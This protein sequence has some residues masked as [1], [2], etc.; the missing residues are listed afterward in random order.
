MAIAVTVY[1][2]EDGQLH[3][4]REDAEFADFS[5]TMRE[6]IGDFLR[7]QRQ[8]DPD[9]HTLRLL[10]DWELWKFGGFAGWLKHRE[11]ELAGDRPPPAPLPVALPAPPLHRSPTPS[12]AVK[13]QHM[14]HVGVVGLEGKLHSLIEAEFKDAFKLTL[15]TP[16]ESAKVSSLKQCHKIFVMVKFIGQPTLHALQAAGHEPQRIH[17]G[18]SALREAMTTL[19]ANS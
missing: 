16:D 9:G 8:Q 5:I 6:D 4:S 19:Y 14:K 7:D 10:C 1:Q 3:R 11:M 18:S 13:A 15:L 17:G 2:S 12:K